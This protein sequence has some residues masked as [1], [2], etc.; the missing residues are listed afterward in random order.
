MLKSFY[1]ALNSKYRVITI[2]LKYI[3]EVGEHSDEVKMVGYTV[4]VV[5]S[6]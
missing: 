4:L 2:I 3:D 6:R 5:E 1:I